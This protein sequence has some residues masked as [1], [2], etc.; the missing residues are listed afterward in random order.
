MRCLIITRYSIPLAFGRRDSSVIDSEWWEHRKSLFLEYCLPS[1]VNQSDQNFEWFIGFHPTA[2]VDFAAQLPSNAHVILCGSMDEFNHEIRRRL[3]GESYLVSTRLD[4]D[5]CLAN[6]FISAIRN[7]ALFHNAN[8]QILGDV[9]ALNFRTGLV[10]DIQNNIVYERDYKASSFVTL[11][12]FVPAE[13]VPLT[14]NNFRHAHISKS[15]DVANISSSKPMWMINIHDRNVG[16]AV[17][18][19]ELGVL[20]KEI[21]A[22]F[23][24]G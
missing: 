12:E 3:R 1:V 23:S 7:F 13:G 20:S 15:V 19:S 22:R 8:M 4:N 17:E 10:Y 9:Y 18:G 2:D 21:A 6:D 5:D 14:V 11:Y 16:N 24:I